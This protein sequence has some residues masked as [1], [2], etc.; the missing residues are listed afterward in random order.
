[1]STGLGVAFVSIEGPSSVVRA[2]VVELRVRSSGLLPLEV[3]PAARPG[4]ALEL[5]AGQV[6]GAVRGETLD[7]VLSV[8]V[9]GTKKKNCR[10]CR[11]K[12]RSF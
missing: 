3:F 8:R 11:G 2:R 5:V 9:R 12:E 10:K 6:L 4:P 7:R 1:M